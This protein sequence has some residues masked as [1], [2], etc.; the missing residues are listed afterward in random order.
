MQRDFEDGALATAIRLVSGFKAAYRRLYKA[1]F[2][3]NGWW[4]GL[5]ELMNRDRIVG[6]MQ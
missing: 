2:C 6:Y 3:V 5:M 1:F 4:G